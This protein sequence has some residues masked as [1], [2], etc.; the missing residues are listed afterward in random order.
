MQYDTICEERKPS[1]EK[2]GN[3]GLRKPEDG[4]AKAVQDCRLRA[5]AL[6]PEPGSLRPS[7]R[8]RIAGVS[9]AAVVLA[10]AG[11]S[12]GTPDTRRV[13]RPRHDERND[14]F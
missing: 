4:S 3:H 8:S 5:A 6:A 10:Q 14:L 1:D 12:A 2:V 11:P 9:A 13:P 7:R